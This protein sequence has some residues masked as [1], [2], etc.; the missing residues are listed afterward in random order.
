MLHCIVVIVVIVVI[1]I[2][3]VIVII[4]VRDDDELRLP[5]GLDA[6]TPWSDQWAAAKLG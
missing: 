1:V 3:I 4:V 6:K 2:I 5:F